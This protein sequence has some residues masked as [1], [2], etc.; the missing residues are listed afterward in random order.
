MVLQLLS[1]SELDVSEW[2]FDYIVLLCS[3]S[4]FTEFR[5]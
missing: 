5:R 1:L 4:L 3:A 2:T